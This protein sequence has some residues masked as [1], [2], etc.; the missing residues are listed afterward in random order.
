MDDTVEAT[1]G[2]LTRYLFIPLHGGINTMLLIGKLHTVQ[3]IMVYQPIPGQW[4]GWLSPC[5]YLQ[6]SS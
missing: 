4:I 5:R 3:I 6:L 1:L 2:I